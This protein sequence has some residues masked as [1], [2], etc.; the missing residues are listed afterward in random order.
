MLATFAVYVNTSEENHLD[1]NKAFVALSFFNLLKV[2]LALL[3][4]II[5]MSV[6][7]GLHYC[8]H[9]VTFQL[10]S[11]IIYFCDWGSHIYIYIYICHYVG[12]FA[13]LF[14]SC[15]ISV[16]FNNHLFL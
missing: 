2:P 16:I 5:S 1:A 11:I 9:H 14:S 12:R 8:F 13:L 10:Y 3:S 6:Q 15:N 4:T 7:V